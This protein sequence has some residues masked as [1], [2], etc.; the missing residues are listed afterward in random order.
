MGLGSSI[1]SC[2]PLG[3]LSLVPLGMWQDS[4]NS[5]QDFRPH[6]VAQELK[7]NGGS[8]LGPRFMSRP[9]L[10]PRKLGHGFP[11]LSEANETE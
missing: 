9:R 5:Q 10:G 11:L 3:T 1:S 2:L 4:I 8:G 6:K 7:Q